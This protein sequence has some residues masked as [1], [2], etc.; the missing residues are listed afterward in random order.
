VSW[1]AISF[2]ERLEKALSEEKL[3]SERFLYLS[4]NFA[5]YFVIINQTL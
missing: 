1:H 4:S 3:L 5:L 2:E